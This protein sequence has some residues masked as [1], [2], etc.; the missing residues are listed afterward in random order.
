M[1]VDIMLKLPDQLYEQAKYLAKQRRQKLEKLLLDEIT[2]TI[3]AKVTATASLYKDTPNEIVH[4]PDEAVER[5][6]NAYI[7]LHPFL[8]NN[9]LGKHVAIYQGQLID[10]DE[11]YDALYMRIDANYPDE[12]VWLDT[13]TEEPLEVI[14][15]RSPTF[16]EE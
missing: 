7:T 13:V 1:T 10:F 6:R 8:K 11:D 4:A 15:L 2:E 14:T 9:F 16:V 12:F 3:T 5:E